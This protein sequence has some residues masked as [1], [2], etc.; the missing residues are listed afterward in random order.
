MKELILCNEDSSQE[1]LIFYKGYTFKIKNAGVGQYGYERKV[2]I[3]L[4]DKEL[5]SNVFKLVSILKLFKNDEIVGTANSEQALIR[6]VTN[7][8]ESLIAAK[9]YIQKY[10]DFVTQEI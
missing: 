7:F 9:E 3:Y 10:V 8:D 6:K 5:K 4:I 2:Y 1:V